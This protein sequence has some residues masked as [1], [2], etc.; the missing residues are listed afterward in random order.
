MEPSANVCVVHG[1]LYND[2]N[3]YISL[4]VINQMGRNVASMFC[5]EIIKICDFV[6]ESLIGILQ[7]I[8][9]HAKLPIIIGKYNL[10]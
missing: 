4:S 9:I 6:Q 2:P 8:E 1:T 3:V 10:C 5:H 7:E